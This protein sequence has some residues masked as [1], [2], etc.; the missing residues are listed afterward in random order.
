MR[1]LREQLEQ[2]RDLLFELVGRD[3]RLRYK[4]SVLGLLWI[5]LLPLAMLLVLL[6]VFTRVVPVGAEHD[7]YAIFVLTGLLS[8]TWFSSGLSAA[9]ESVVTSRDLLRL[10]RF[11]APLLPV[12]AVTSHLVHLLL[13][14]PVLLIAVVLQLGLPSG[15]VVALPLV[16]IAQFT[17]MTGLAYF[18]AAWHVRFR[19]VG[20]LVTVVLRLLFWATPI[21]YVVAAVPAAVRPVYDLNPVVHLIEGYR[22]VLLDHVWPSTAVAYPLLIGC[23]LTA[24]GLRSFRRAAPRFV[25]EL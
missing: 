5:Q 2:P 10:P 16:F 23:L 15:V 21:F 11:P 12:V 20:H 6:F 17:L 24:V 7:H 18:L 22:A 8:W 3:L 19:D 4:R 1:R 14:L 9:T 13:A 25:E